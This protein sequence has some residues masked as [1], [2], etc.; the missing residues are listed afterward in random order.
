MAKPIYH[1][2]WRDGD[3]V[4]YSRE[5]LT[6]LADAHRIAQRASRRFGS[7][8]VNQKTSPGWHDVIEQWRDGKRQNPS[9][10][11]P[12]GKAVR[13]KNFTGTIRRNA[14]GTVSVVGRAKK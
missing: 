1:V 2:F 12:A 11:N 3:D 14:N 5:N 4:I 10:K 6:S 8:H 9:K 7:A 13:L